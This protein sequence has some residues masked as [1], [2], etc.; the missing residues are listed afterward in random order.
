M[1]P[2]GRSWLLQSITGE[3]L[4][5]DVSAIAVVNG[6]G[7]SGCHYSGF[8]TPRPSARTSTT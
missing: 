6:S 5:F 8:V 2:I 1:S 7:S 4:S 3:T